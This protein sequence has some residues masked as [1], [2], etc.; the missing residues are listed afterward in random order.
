M[1]TNRQS[2]HEVKRNRVREFLSANGLDALVLS[3]RPNFS[4]YLCGSH[5]QVNGATQTGIASILIE[6][7]DHYLLTSVIEAPRLMAEETEAASDLE[8]IEFPWHDPE[9]SARAFEKVL[10]G[11]KA[12]SDAP[13]PG[14]NALPLP[15][16]FPELRFSLI[17]QEMERYRRTGRLASKAIEA[18]CKAIAPGMTEHEIAG[19]TSREVRARGMN[20]W[21][22]LV[23]ADDRV[24]RFRHPIP[25]DKR[26]ERYCMVVICV[27]DAGLIVSVTRLLSFEP[28]SRELAERHRAVCNVDAAFILSTRVGATLGEIFSQGMAAY[29]EQGF[30]GEWM[31]H[32]QGGLTGYLPREIVAHPGH[33]AKVRANQAFAWNPSIKGTKSEDTILLTESGIEIISAAVDWPMIEC[34]YQGKAIARP[35]I[36][37]KSS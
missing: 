35:D 18:S 23:A 5:N 27:E 6:K 33:P 9:A 31:L 29:E 20:P 25:T 16:S 36:L 4:W 3:L 34:K 12:A 13:L 15:E 24:E 8:L 26:V 14:L 28:L 1:M 11:K 22:I 17:E 19:L 10:S 21:V 30:A 37:I 32:H 2:E 7:D